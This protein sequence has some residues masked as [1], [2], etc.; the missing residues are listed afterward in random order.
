ML[1]SNVNYSQLS[2]CDHPA[3]TD[4]PIIRTAAKS[5][6]K[7]NYRHLLTDISFRY[8][9]LT[10][11]TT[12]TRGPYS[13]CA[14]KGVDCSFFLKYRLLLVN[15][16]YFC[17]DQES[18][19]ERT[20][21]QPNEKSGTMVKKWKEK[22][23]FFAIYFYNWWTRMNLW[24]ISRFRPLFSEWNDNFLLHINNFLK[25]ISPPET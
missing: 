21:V 5:Q 18:A 16:T 10:L 3:I 14:I 11:M 1:K 2:P 6:E 12:L 8:Y 22:N 7:V 13:V 24:H 25:L 15:R 17:V 19:S 23:D 9:G 4:T 20:Y